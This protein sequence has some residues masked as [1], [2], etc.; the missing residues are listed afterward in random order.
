MF[1]ELHVEDD[2]AGEQVSEEVPSLPWD[3]IIK[4]TS[5][6]EWAERMLSKYTTNYGFYILILRWKDNLYKLQQQRYFER[7]NFQFFHWIEY[8][9][10]LI[11]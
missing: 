6:Q 8:Q 2:S 5:G 10:R 1:T 7:E 3:I 9:Q 4:V 11:F